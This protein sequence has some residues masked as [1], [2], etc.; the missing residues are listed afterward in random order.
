MIKAYSH[1]FIK[2]GLISILSLLI[3]SCG[4]QLRGEYSIPES[5]HTL[6]LSSYDSYS[7]LTRLVTQQLTINHIAVTSPAADLPNLHLASESISE[8]TLS[9]YKNTRTAEIELTYRVSYHVAVPNTE[10]LNLNTSVTR[11]YLDNPLT[12]LAK[13][14][15]RDMIEDE[16]RQQA[17]IQIIRQ[18]ARV[19][20]NVTDE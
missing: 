1:S 8:R 6:S 10:I 2:I 16:M 13:S 18:M 14:I 15:E 9:L 5:L 4:F 19:N 3:T 20:A 7:R 12:A 11:N 17:A